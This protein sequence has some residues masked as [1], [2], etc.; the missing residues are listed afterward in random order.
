VL[1]RNRARPRCVAGPRCPLFLAG[2]ELMRIQRSITTCRRSSPAHVV[3]RS[4]RAAI[5]YAAPVSSARRKVKIRLTHGRGCNFERKRIVA[6]DDAPQRGRILRRRQPFQHKG[7]V[8][9]AIAAMRRR[10][11]KLTI[12]RFFRRLWFAFSWL[13]LAAFLLFGPVGLFDRNPQPRRLSRSD[14]LFLTLLGEVSNSCIYAFPMSLPTC[15]RFQPKRGF[16]AQL[17]ISIIPTPR[18][19]FNDPRAV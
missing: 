11:R 18:P 7:P 1:D 19:G 4:P 3:T 2:R 17:W 13:R 5:Q 9:I 10:G 6:L 16:S 8:T 14:C 15:Q 12:P